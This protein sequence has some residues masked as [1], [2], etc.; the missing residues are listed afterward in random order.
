MKKFFRLMILA[1]LILA[2]VCARADEQA[3]IPHYEAG[4]I[5]TF[6]R[7]EQD[8]NPDNGAEKIEWIVLD[9]QDGKCLLLSR[10]CLDVQPY[11]SKDRKITWKDSSL[12]K[13]LNGDFL[14]TAFQGLEQELIPLKTVNNSKKQGYKKW[15]KTKG[16]K[17]T[18]DRVF[19]LSCAEAEKY[20]GVT[21]GGGQLNPAAQAEP[22]AYAV[23]K[24]AYCETVHE[25]DG[26]EAVY[27]WWWLRSPGYVQNAAAG[28]GGHGT[29]LDSGAVWEEACV[30]PA[31]WVKLDEHTAIYLEEKP[32]IERKTSGDYT[33][34]VLENGTAEITRYSGKDETAVI[35]D[36]LDGHPVTAIGEEAFMCSS[37]LTSVVIPDGVT[38]IGD[39]AFYACRSMAS[40]TIPGSVETIGSLAFGNCSGLASVTIPD[41]VKT[42]G[43]D[44]FFGCGGLT[45]VV[46]PD[47]VETIGNSAF[48][49]CSGLASVTI[50]AGVK[51]FGEF[52][53]YMCKGLTS[54]TLKDGCAAI[55]GFMFCDCKSL[56]S[57]EIPDSVRSIGVRAFW[58]CSSLAS[59][60][61]PD[62][63]TSIGTEAFGDCENLVSVTIPDSVS[64]VG[65]SPF[66]SCGALEEIRISGDHPYLDMRDGVL[67]SKADHRLICFTNAF[68]GGAYTVPDGTAEIDERAF[69][70]CDTLTSITLPD[71]MTTIREEVFGYCTG[72]ESARIPESVT[73]I[74]ENTFYGCP[75]T[76]KVT[77]DR[78]SYAEKYCKKNKLKRA[79]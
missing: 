9:T 5:V 6:G 42:I 63:V 13:W 2:A 36:A 68:A 19:L 62:G 57:I 45:S 37:S 52:V 73:L 10:Y 65:A 23:G 29:L 26:T 21:Y 4:S 71:S 49:D 24:G 39:Y 18:K 70:G 40:V 51:D 76:M 11:Q 77:V 3:E 55:P 25:A 32:L 27:A 43:S 14:N 66:T 64:S 22:T 56:V 54:V 7:Y 12:R 50:P 38:A 48:G 59:V 61:V 41:G 31:I 67:F 72:L 20:L 34:T 17:N 28:V 47:S 78:G 53:F 46:I 1:A 33:Y 30:R 35:P 69:W 58:A 74:G 16:G 60:E 75:R 8:G 44:A 79:Y 15:T